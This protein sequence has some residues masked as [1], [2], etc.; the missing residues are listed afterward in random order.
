M[1]KAK[2]MCE[3]S[4]LSNE[5]DKLY[6]EALIAIEN[7][8]KLKSDDP[9]IVALWAI[10][11][12]KNSKRSTNTVLEQEQLLVQSAEKFLRV[13][14]NEYVTGLAFHR[15]TEIQENLTNGHKIRNRTGKAVY[16]LAGELTKEGGSV[17]NWKNRWFVVDDSTFTYYKDKQ[18][19]EA[20]PVSGAPAKPKGTVPFG[21]ILDVICHD[22]LAKCTNIPAS[23][24]PKKVGQYCIHV[25]T[26]ERTFNI[27]GFETAQE[28]IEWM[29]VMKQ[30]L[31]L[32]NVKKRVKAYLRDHK[33]LSEAIPDDTFFTMDVE[34][35][36]Q[37]LKGKKSSKSKK[38]DEAGSTS[39][40]T[41]N[42]SLSSSLDKIEQIEKEEEQQ[43]VEEKK[44]RKSKKPEEDDVTLPQLP[45]PPP[46]TSELK[47]EKNPLSTSIDGIDSLILRKP[48]ERSSTIKQTEF[49]YPILE[50]KLKDADN[51]TAGKYMKQLLK[52]WEAE[53]TLR[54]VI[55]TLY[56]E[57]PK[58][59]LLKVNDVAD[60]R[61]AKFGG[62]KKMDSIINLPPDSPKPT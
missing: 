2:K 27:L 45:V 23:S 17:K 56:E 38:D 1:D 28:S 57:D 60:F 22:D 35:R 48:L 32:Y 7:A 26:K 36:I 19:W 13:A 42:P 15:L 16:H 18:E 41:S 54:K 30:V 47:K 55:K 5:G 9:F 58:V 50:Q 12:H 37:K 14:D 31:K 11:L 52:K 21:D 8:A 43:K 3:Q 53:G 34:K 51:E 6:K 39:P 10:I 59:F 33:R 24:R 46:A 25:L 61:M 40:T 62:L 4:E 29:S 20:G 44:N 49:T